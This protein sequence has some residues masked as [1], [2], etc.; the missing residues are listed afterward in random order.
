[1][2]CHGSSRLARGINGGNCLMA[3]NHQRS[4][5]EAPNHKR[6][7]SYA[8]SWALRRGVYVV[9]LPRVLKRS[10][11]AKYGI[12]ACAATRVT[13]DKAAKPEKATMRNLVGVESEHVEMLNQYQNAHKGMSSDVAVAAKEI[14]FNM[15]IQAVKA[16]MCVERNDIKEA[17]ARA[18]R[19]ER[20]SESFNKRPNR[21]NDIK[22]KK[23]R[24]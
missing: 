8:H 15:Y 1:M 20:G 11:A 22:E 14:F 3:A 13:Y 12:S 19:R 21:R 2:F 24:Q 17:A 18:F 6:V 9:V 10:G 23:Y 4:R 5:R 7:A 16:E